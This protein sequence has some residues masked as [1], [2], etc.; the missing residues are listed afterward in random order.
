MDDR[1]LVIVGP[2]AVGK[3]AM[4][5]AMAERFGGEI[6]SADSRQVYRH[7]DIGTGKPS[8]QDRSAVPHHLVD[9][10][11]PDEE[12][13]LALFLRQ[14]TDAIK[15]TQRGSKLPILVGGTGQYV[16]AILEGWKVPEVPPDPE[17]RGRLQRR[18]D[19]E[20]YAELH[21]ELSRLD[22][23]SAA[24]IDARNVRRVIRALEVH[25]TSPAGQ[26]EQP[27]KEPPPFRAKLVG[28]A[29]DRC[30]L[31]Q[32]IDRRVDGMMDS[33][34]ID[35]VRALLEMGYS[36]E[37]PSL[38]SLGYRE[39]VQHLGAELPLDEAE[40]H[41]KRR[42]RRFARQQQAWFRP[43]DERIE[44]FD[45]ESELRGAEESVAKWLETT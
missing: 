42:T 15:E 37:L 20:G 36:P 39:L 1:L 32:R 34:W 11:D 10:I 21:A 28:L 43:A 38:S 19:R 22:P 44:W 23:A 18:A 31:Y 2:T 5:M 16:W 7:M 14:A 30:G 24:R 17:L 40:Q 27:R 41:I 8:L 6:V 9:V 33:G 35:E 26:R 4:A 3:S 13:S 12:Y 45:A 29:L 25:S